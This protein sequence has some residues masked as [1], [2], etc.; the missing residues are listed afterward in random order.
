MF[1]L[2]CCALTVSGSQAA[3]P[4]D[5]EAS[6]NWWANDF[7]TDLSDGEVNAGAFGGELQLWWDQTWGLK[8]SLYRSDLA[9]SAGM[10]DTDYLSLDLKQRLFSATE[11]N[12]VAAGVGYERLNIND[13]GNS[14]GLR[15][16]VEG[17]LGLVGMLYAYGQTAWMPVFEDTNSREDLDALEFEAG[18]AVS[19]LPFIQ[20][21]AGWRKFALDFTDTATG[22]GRNTSSSG[23]V[24]EAGVTW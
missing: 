23:P 18:V 2:V 8:G 13:G 21:S 16:L 10:N 3:G 11:N 20:L 9:D 5:G 17:R 15:L 4:L 12:Y 22:S 1:L 6:L 7:D 14:Q 24:F 19:P